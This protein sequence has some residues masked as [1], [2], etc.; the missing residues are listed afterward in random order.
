MTPAMMSKPYQ[1]DQTL[2]KPRKRESYLF[3]KLGYTLPDTFRKRDDDLC[4]VDKWLNNNVD[5]LLESLL[6]GTPNVTPAKVQAGTS[7]E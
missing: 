3:D 4:T 5:R 1:D 6:D 7:C 2:D